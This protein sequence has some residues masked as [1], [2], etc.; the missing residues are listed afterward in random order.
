M[1]VYLYQAFNAIVDFRQI[2]KDYIQSHY[3]CYA[4]LS[5]VRLTTTTDIQERHAVSSKVAAIGWLKNVHDTFCLRL[6]HY[7]HHRTCY[8]AEGKQRKGR[9]MGK[10]WKGRIGPGKWGG[11]SVAVFGEIWLSHHTLCLARVWQLRNY[12]STVFSN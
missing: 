10:G 5:V 9:G 3:W 7:M 11:F 4:S 8:N 2:V 6:P 12:S 1:S